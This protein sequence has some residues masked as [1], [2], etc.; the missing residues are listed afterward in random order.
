VRGNRPA[1]SKPCWFADIDF[2]EGV[3]V[4]VVVV[5]GVV[6]RVVTA[7]AVGVVGVVGVPGV[8]VL[9]AVVVGRNAATDTI[10]RSRRMLMEL[11]VMIFPMVKTNNLLNLLFVMAIA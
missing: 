10:K 9:S 7:G 8:G 5:A 2:L 3:R 1:S 6:V 4:S 11:E